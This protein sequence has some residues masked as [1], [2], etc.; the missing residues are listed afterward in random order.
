MIPDDDGSGHVPVVQAVAGPK[1]TC[2]RGVP[3]P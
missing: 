2:P 3:L 1:P